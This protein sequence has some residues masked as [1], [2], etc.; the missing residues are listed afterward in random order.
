MKTV[1]GGILVFCGYDK[2]MYDQQYF[3]VGTKS[4]VTLE[5]FP[6]M[7][8]PTNGNAGCAY[9]NQYFYVFGGKSDLSNG[10]NLY[11]Q[12]LLLQGNPGVNIIKVFVNDPPDK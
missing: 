9:D 10:G 6:R 1:F 2:G 11:A 5:I 4:W 8:F 3:S 7:T 12:R